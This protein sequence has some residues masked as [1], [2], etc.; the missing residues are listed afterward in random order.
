M[1]WVRNDG[2]EAG[3]V[4]LPDFQRVKDRPTLPSERLGLRAKVVL[5]RREDAQRKLAPE[6]S[7]ARKWNAYRIP[8]AKVCVN[9]DGSPMAA[10]E[11]NHLIYAVAMPLMG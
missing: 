7:V 8:Y 6:R 11:L 9:R 4:L 1:T 10:G 2:L 3:S 5:W